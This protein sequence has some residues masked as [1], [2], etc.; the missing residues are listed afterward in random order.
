MLLAIAPEGTRKPVEHWKTGFYR[1]ALAAGVP[2]V[3]GFIDNG[4]KR[5]GFGGV[6]QPT[7]DADR[8]IARLRE[9]YRGMRRR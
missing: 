7:G 8:D 5:V 2:V 6:L 9:G 1:I 3:A 4:R